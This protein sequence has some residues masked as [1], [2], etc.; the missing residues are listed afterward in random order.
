MIR[1]KKYKNN[2]RGRRCTM[3]IAGV[4]SHDAD[5]VVFTHFP[6][7]SHGIGIKADD[8]VGGD[9]CSSCH[10]AIDRRTKTPAEFEEHRH[11]YLMRSMV[12]TIKS[13]IE[14]GIVIIK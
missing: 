11:F 12:R 1:S 9:A 8:I 13:R 6:D 4:C 2:A 14:A 5:T 3:Q 7:E 10:D